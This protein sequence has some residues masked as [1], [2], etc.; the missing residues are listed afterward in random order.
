MK[1]YYILAFGTLLCSRFAQVPSKAM[2]SEEPVQFLYRHQIEGLQ[3][4]NEPD[5][6]QPGWLG[7][8]IVRL[9]K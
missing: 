3:T 8:R 1:L 6:E 4:E 2:A 7:N 9:Q 5:S